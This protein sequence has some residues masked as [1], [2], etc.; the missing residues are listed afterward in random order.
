MQNCIHSDLSTS[1]V[2]TLTVLVLRIFFVC[3]FVIGLFEANWPACRSE[4]RLCMEIFCWK[5]LLVYTRHDCIPFQ[6][7]RVTAFGVAFVYWC[8]R[9][10]THK[11]NTRTHEIRL[12]QSQIS[13]CRSRAIAFYLKYFPFN[14][15]PIAI[16]FGNIVFNIKSSRMIRS[17][18]R[19]FYLAKVKIERIFPLWMLFNIYIDARTVAAIDFFNRHFFK[20]CV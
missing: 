15:K 13:V 2:D 14:V 1:Y 19:L 11:H 9:C 3:L 6:R 17:I 10:E 16:C 18:L 12:N 7:H 5:R 20:F 8:H 4:Y